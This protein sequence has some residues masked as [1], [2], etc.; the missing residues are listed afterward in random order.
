MNHL[1]NL[2]GKL[3][4]SNEVLLFCRVLR[5]FQKS[6]ASGRNKILASKEKEI[7][8]TSDISYNINILTWRENA[9]HRERIST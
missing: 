4:Q 1:E 6:W 3:A 7:I 9:S 2:V 5:C 8:F